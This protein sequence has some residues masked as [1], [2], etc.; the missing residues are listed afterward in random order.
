MTEAEWMASGDLTAMRAIRRTAC[1]GCLWFDNGNGA[2]SIAGGQKPCGQCDNGPILPE[3]LFSERKMRLFTCAM[4][5]QVWHLIED[6]RGRNAVRVAER[7]ANGDA[8]LDELETAWNRAHEAATDANAAYETMPRLGFY[9]SDWRPEY[10]DWSRC[11][12]MFVAREAGVTKEQQVDLFREIVGNPFRPVAIV[13]PW[14][15]PSDGEFIEFVGEGD[16]RRIRRWPLWRTPLVAKMAQTIYDERAFGDLPILADAL[17][18]AGCDSPDLMAHL[19]SPG[20][21]VRGCWALDL[22]LGKE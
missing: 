22:L 14:L 20:P 8:D 7:F 12:A 9:V 13:P 16:E 10:L 21:H 1:C 5:R 19:R 11:T 4:A 2:V 17:E 15:E 6:E 18:D 3:T